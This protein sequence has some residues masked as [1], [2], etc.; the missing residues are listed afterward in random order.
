[1]KIAY[2]NVFLIGLNLYLCKRNNDDFFY[3]DFIYPEVIKGR[4]EDDDESQDNKSRD[5]LW[6]FLHDDKNKCLKSFYKKTL[7]GGK[8]KKISRRRKDNFKQK[9]KKSRTK[10]RK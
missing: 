1:M 7:R 4:N 2:S 5:E 10:R 8:Y 9:S 3:E 6:K